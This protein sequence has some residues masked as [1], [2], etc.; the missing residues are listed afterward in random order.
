MSYQSPTAL[1]SQPSQSEPLAPSFPEV[2]T[3]PHPADVVVSSSGDTPFMR[4]PE[5]AIPQDTMLE[6]LR[7]YDTVIIVDDSESMSWYGRWAEV[8]SSTVQDYSNRET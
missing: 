2:Q 8:M 5:S 3:N 7:G 4:K 1:S 6:Y